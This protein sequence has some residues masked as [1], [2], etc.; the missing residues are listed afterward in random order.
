MKPG[1][2]SP[3]A[4]YHS[5]AC[6]GCSPSSLSFLLAILAAFR[7]ALSSTSVQMQHLD[8][9][10][11]SQP[12][13]IKQA[14]TGGK[15][16]RPDDKQRAFHRSALHLVAGLSACYQHPFPPLTNVVF[17]QCSW[18]GSCRL[19]FM[20][21]IHFLHL[22]SP[23]RIISGLRLLFEVWQFDKARGRAPPSDMLV[24]TE[25]KYCRTKNKNDR[26]QQP[27]TRLAKDWLFFDRL[28]RKG[29][30]SA[31]ASNYRKKQPTGA[32][33]PLSVSPDLPCS[34][35]SARLSLLELRLLSK[36]QMAFR[37]VYV[38]F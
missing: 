7:V 1:L 5:F 11:A 16:K 38:I 22:L 28:T 4:G 21:F 2:V 8:M 14:G 23:A 20:F 26:L 15:P 10:T 27:L 12:P 31:R 18:L 29:H 24:Q 25:I 36:L 13:R 3:R 6:N 37:K 17:S 34:A 19:F 32:Y 33:V 9:N 30:V 35:A